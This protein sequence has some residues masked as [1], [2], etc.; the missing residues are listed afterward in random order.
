MSA[1]MGRNDLQILRDA[2]SVLYRFIDYTEYREPYDE[3]AHDWASGVASDLE[4][5]IDGMERGQ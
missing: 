1:K 5:F 3:E 2:V 4:D